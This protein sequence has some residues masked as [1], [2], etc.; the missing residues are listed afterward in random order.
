MLEL[1]WLDPFIVMVSRSTKIQHDI[2]RVKIIEVTFAT[3]LNNCYYP[4][5]KNMI[6]KLFVFFP[7]FTFFT[8]PS[9]WAF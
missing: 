9:Y 7:P 6:W 1:Y 5:F 4:R 8:L 2:Q 3:S